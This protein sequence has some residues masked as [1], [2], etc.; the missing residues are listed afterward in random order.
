MP[1]VPLAMILEA[2]VEVQQERHK[3]DDVDVP[4]AED[5]RLGDLFNPKGQQSVMHGANEGYQRAAQERSD[6]DDTWGDE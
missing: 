4:N 2:V 6:S 5:F 1:I 3:D